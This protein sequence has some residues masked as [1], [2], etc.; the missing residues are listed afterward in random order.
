MI[1][2]G[3]MQ[4][5]TTITRVRSGAASMIELIIPGTPTHSKTTGPDGVSPI[6]SARR[7]TCHQGSGPGTR[8]SLSIVLTPSLNRSLALRISLRGCL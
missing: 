8:V 1:R 2:S 6:L 7:K 3:S 5:P 4:T